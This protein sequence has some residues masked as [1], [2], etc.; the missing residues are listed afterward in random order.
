MHKENL[1]SWKGRMD[2]D[3]HFKEDRKCDTAPIVAVYVSCRQLSHVTNTWD[4][5]RGNAVG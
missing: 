4:L 1:K 2:N 3:T 5:G